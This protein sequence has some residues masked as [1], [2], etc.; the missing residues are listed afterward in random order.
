MKGGSSFEEKAG[1]FLLFF[2]IEAVE[3]TDM[4]IFLSFQLEYGFALA[5][6]GIKP[7]E[8]EET[9]HSPYFYL[10]KARQLTVISLL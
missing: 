4:N 3:E 2:L 1:N 10:A 7:Q 8:N 5:G 6:N 9:F